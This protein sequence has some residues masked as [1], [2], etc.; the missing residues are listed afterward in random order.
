MEC[1][2]NVENS[3]Y[4]IY[5]LATLSNSVMD[6]LASMI[7]MINARVLNAEDVEIKIISEED[8]AGRIYAK[9]TN[10]SDKTIY[11]W[12]GKHP[13]NISYHIVGVGGETLLHDGIR[14]PLISDIPPGETL[15]QEVHLGE[16]HELFN[17][18]NY[19][20]ITLLQE[21]MFWFDSINPS[22]TTILPAHP[23][24]FDGDKL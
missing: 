13:I 10:L 15:C 5:A 12:F 7:N 21:G 24:N 3:H 17:N 22:F 9:V 23:R 18:E 2:E 16:H 11:P 14:T 20:V 4:N 6:E 8:S 19:L 1:T